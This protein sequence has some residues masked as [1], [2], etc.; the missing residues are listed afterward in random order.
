MPSRYAISA[1]LQVALVLAPTMV[2]AQMAG[3]RT[4]RLAT[5]VYA[6]VRTT[7]VGDP[8]D[9]NTLVIINHADVVVV[10]G[11]ITPRSTRAVIAGIR[12]LTRKPVMRGTFIRPAIEGACGELDATPVPT[13]PVTCQASPR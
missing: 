7:R 1:M 3:L 5:N 10:D 6:M 2:A 9:A 12:R 11:N 4:E 13:V 8:S